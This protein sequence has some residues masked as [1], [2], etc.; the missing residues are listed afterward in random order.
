MGAVLDTLTAI[1][2]AA[3][4]GAGSPMVAAAGDSLAVRATNAGKTARLLNVWTQAQTAGIF[5]ITSP[6][7][8]DNTRGLRFRE[9]VTDP[10]PLLPYGVSQT[11]FQTDTLSLT[12]S[13]AATAGNIDSATLLIYYDDI[14]GGESRLISFEDMK[15]RLV[16]LVTVENTITAGAGGGYT[17][18]EAINAESDL[19]KSDSDYALLGYRVGINCCS[20]TWRGADTSNFRVSGPGDNLN[21]DGT[22]EW[23]ANLAKAFAMPLIPVF[24]SNNRAGILMEVVQNQAAAAVTVSSIFGRLA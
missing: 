16:E 15:K 24:N 8:H 23:F 9:P 3:A 21:G 6:K 14:Q 19:L 10:K 7:L 5:Q 1:V 17:G 18:S 20:V 22:A 4:A 2:T 12:M 13:G 11:L